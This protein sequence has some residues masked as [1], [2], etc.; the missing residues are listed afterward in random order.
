MN[1]SAKMRKPGALYACIAGMIILNNLFI[2]QLMRVSV[3]VTLLVL[4]TFQVLLATSTRG[5]SMSTE[6][7]TIGL[8]H[9]NL[10]SGLKKI[11][12]QTVFRFYYRKDEVKVLTNLNLPLGTR[13]VEETLN[14]LLQ[15]TFFSFR[16][17]DG[18]ILLER[19]TQQT[20]YEIKG[21]VLSSKYTGV[22]FA[23]VSIKNIALNKIVQSTLTDTAGYFKLTATEKGDYLLRISAL[24]ADTLS[25]AVTL[26]DARVVQLPDIVLNTNI[27][28]LK[29]VT[30]VSKKPLIEQKIDRT[31]LNV[32]A[33]ISNAGTTA[34]DVLQKS[35]GVQVDE[36]NGNISLKGKLGVV[37][38]IDDKPTYLS[39]ED[40][41]SYL[42]SLPSST[43]DQIEIMTNPPAKYDA[44]GNAGVINIRTKR[45]KAKGFNG[46]VNVSAIR[47]RKK[48]KTNNSVN[49]NYRDD[50]FN[51]F[52]NLSYNVQNS[53]NNLDIYRKYKNADGSTNSFFLQHNDIDR[54][55]QAVNAKVGADYYQSDKTTWGI[56][57]NGL[58][59]PSTSNYLNTSRLLNSG[60][61]LD[62]IILAHNVEKDRFKNGGINL[63]YRH[64]YDKNGRELTADIDYIGYQTDRNQQFNNESYLPDQTLVSQGLLL[65]KLPSNINILS[66]KTDYT[67]PLQNGL[68][69]AAGLKSSYTKT[70]NLADYTNTVNN[71]TTPDYSKSN[72]FIYKE[73][74]NAAYLN[75]NKDFKKLSIQAGLR[76]ENTGS[77]G[78]QLGNAIKPD[79]AFKRNYTDLFPTLYF[80]YKLDTAGNNQ[81]GLKYGRRIDRP[82]YRDLNPFVSPLDKFTYYVGNPLLNPAY[83]NNIE[84]SHTF[85]NRITTT[86]S[87]G[88]TKDDV[89]ETIQIVNGIYYSRPGNI[90][91]TVTKSISVDATLDPAPWFS[92][93][94]YT[95]VTHNEYKSSFYT[96]LLDTKGTYFYVQPVLQFNIS[97]TWNAQLDGFYQSKVTAAQ[98]IAGSRGQLN[99]GVSKKL[100]A[101]TTLKLTVNDIFYSYV[102]S[103]VI[104]NLA[105]T[106]ASYHN[107]ID[108]RLAVLALSYRF[109][110]AIS[111]QRKHEA[112]GAQSEQNRAGN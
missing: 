38:F 14:E 78:H 62:S 67:H 83:S 33:L 36:Q 56:V 8:R 58:Y 101:S 46:G 52:G 111:N 110:K 74:I 49:F 41:Q 47:G 4:T 1:I 99:G 29:E 79:S 82:Y 34:L 73:N 89:S 86:V 28:H 95:E 88:K 22:E 87:Y 43:L 5:Q 76:V 42:R 59:R 64:Q 85:K 84:L 32:D 98:F 81:F 57:L 24:G 93:H 16:Q 31:V 2:R 94:I 61:Q 72:H 40:L 7:V 92:F 30:I 15:N 107:K 26:A 54:D 100:S 106:D 104:N 3:V 11:E 17:I 102:N 35:P 112:N 75:L 48:F 66:V 9:D 108:T 23:S 21:R 50:K 96:G 12:Q 70:D 69:L 39:G 90:G 105:L 65:G 10:T 45:S 19:K 109:G 25:V 53:F 97:K 6:K 80:S 91:S 103:G 68:K 13:T 55:A 51:V 44:A 71:V 37:I 63:N 18:N 20:D 77:D 27:T 60:S